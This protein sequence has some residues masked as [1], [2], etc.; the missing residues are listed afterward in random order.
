[1]WSFLLRGYC[2][3]Y[4]NSV[5]ECTIDGFEGSFFEKKVV[6]F[7]ELRLSSDDTLV[8]GL[9]PISQKKMADRVKDSGCCVVIWDDII[10][11]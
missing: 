2:P 5:D 7:N 8:I 11:R 4:W 6:P 9:N 1:M 10:E 3:E